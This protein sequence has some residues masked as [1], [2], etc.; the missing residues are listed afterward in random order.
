MALVNAEKSLFNLT[1][2]ELCVMV[3]VMKR[4]RSERSVRGIA[5]L[6]GKRRAIHLIDVENLIGSC[7]MSVTDVAALQRDYYSVAGV[8]LRDHV[9]IATGPAAAPAA[10]FGWQ[11]GRRLVRGGVDGADRALLEVIAHESLSSRYERVVVAS[12]DGVFAEAC[13]HLQAE[14]CKL[15]VVTRIGALSLRL[16]LAV[17]DVRFVD[18]AASQGESQGEPA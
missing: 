6:L 15:T 7:V 8:Q 5:R 13:A 16:R 2:R 4:R 10:W 1:S 18:R 9:V 17:R 14:G 3:T 11:G 12:G